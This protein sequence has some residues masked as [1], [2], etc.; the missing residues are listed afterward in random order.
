M[1]LTDIHFDKWELQYEN[2]GPIKESVF[3][4][5]HICCQPMSQETVKEV[6]GS[7]L[8]FIWDTVLQVTNDKTSIIDMGGGPP[9]R[10]FPGALN[11]SYENGCDFRKIDDLINNGKKYDLIIS[12][13][14]IEHIPSEDV[15]ITLINWLKILSP[16]GEI[17]ICGPHRCSVHWSCLFGP[18]VDNNLDE[19]IQSHLWAPTASC[20]G[21]FLVSRGMI[22]LGYEDH[23]C[24]ANSWWVHLQNSPFGLDY[25]W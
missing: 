10:G 15:Q 9:G 22:L 19:Q 21:N 3:P 8:A 6:S 20:I 5:W 18:K 25:R 7:G 16:K 1:I 11:Y 14:A 4:V 12:S 13:H 24:K 2:M 23:I 17:F